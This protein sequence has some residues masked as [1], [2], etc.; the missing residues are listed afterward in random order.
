MEVIVTNYDYTI[1]QY[2]T[3]QNDMWL[4]IFRIN[5][6]QYICINMVVQTERV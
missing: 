6:S 3:Q 2:K 1:N 4:V 5:Q